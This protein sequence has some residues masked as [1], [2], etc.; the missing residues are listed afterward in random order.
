MLNPIQSDRPHIFDLVRLCVLQIEL[1]GRKSKL[2]MECFTVPTCALPPLLDRASV[3]AK[4]ATM[5]SGQP[6]ATA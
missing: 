1:A 5:A 6:Y 4:P 3:E 2:L